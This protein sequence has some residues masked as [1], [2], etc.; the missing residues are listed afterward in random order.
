MTI[1]YSIQI[2]AR[3]ACMYTCIGLTGLVFGQEPLKPRVDEA[4]N[5]ATEI[6][7]A[8][9]D[10]KAALLGSNKSHTVRGSAWYGLGLM[11]RN[12]PGDF[13]NGVRTLIAVAHTQIDLPLLPWDGTFKRVAEEKLP[14]LNGKAYVDYDPN[15]REFV[16]TIFALALIQHGDRISAQDTLVL[17]NAIKHAINGEIKQKRLPPTYTNIAL[18][19]GFLWTFAGQRF[20]NEKY[21]TDG[22][23]WTEKIF[24]SFQENH[25]FDEFNSPTYCGVDLYALALLRRYGAT[26]RLR[27]LGASMEADQWRDIARFYHA[28]LRNLAGPYDRSYGM[29]MTRYASLVGLWLSFFLP[30][31]KMPF[32]AFR[33]SMDHGGDF[34][35]AL[36]YAAVGTQI[37]QEILKEFSTFS[38]ERLVKRKIANGERIATAWLGENLMIGAEFTGLSRGI[39]TRTSQFHPVTIHWKRTDGSINWI[40]L[41][42]ISLCDCIASK[43]GVSITTD[44]GDVVFRI[45]SPGS[46]VKNITQTHWDLPNLSIHVESDSK[47]AKI[48]IE[49]NDTFITYQ[50]VKHISIHTVYKSN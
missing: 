26:A 42:K 21:L 30:N 16:G 37:P 2:L 25:S 28:G 32:P 10:S 3:Y 50:D 20:H 44:T 27:E 4:F 11:T 35:C 5:I 18:M 22:E 39:L 46:D 7:D 40:K 13:E 31:D 41:T 34:F 23:A 43:N 6:L 12:K 14:P 24:N 45:H 19:Y 49:D 38:G 36:P 17:E 47:K 8:R 33:T 48:R 15:W 1:P 9:W 29:D